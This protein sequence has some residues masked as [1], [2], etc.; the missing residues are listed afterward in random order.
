MFG[1]L[2]EAKKQAEE[3]KSKLSALKVTGM[4]GQ[5]RVKIRIDGNKKIDAVELDEQMLKP[6]F[7]AELEECILKALEDAMQQADNISQAEMRHLL[8]NLPG[9]GNILK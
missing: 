9:L 8:G 4:D 1:K 7:K 3:I 6:E 2:L 5:G